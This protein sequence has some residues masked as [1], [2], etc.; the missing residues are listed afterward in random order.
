MQYQVRRYL[1][2]GQLPTN[3]VSY[4]AR[5]YAHVRAKA[6]KIVE[7]NVDGDVDSMHPLV[8]EQ[9][10]LYYPKLSTKFKLL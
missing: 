1:S 6:M 7:L 3:G 2:L 9:M 10:A 8:V 5:P 4:A